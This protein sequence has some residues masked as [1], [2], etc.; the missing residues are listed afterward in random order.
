MQFITS[1][2]PSW[3]ARAKLLILGSMPGEESLRQKQ[4]Y[5]FKHNAFWRIMGTVFDFDPRLPY[6][7]RLEML[8]ENHVAL[9]DVLE[10]CERP[11]S[12]DG[13]IRNPK[14]NN[15][16]DLAAALP[17]LRKIICN[18]TAAGRYFEKFF[19][20]LEV[21]AEVLPSTSPAAARLTF[22]EKLARWR[23]A[24]ATPMV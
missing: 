24:L 9:W 20:G 15:I 4:Y 8:R 13:S 10:R 17:G 18:G 2:P 22:E 7:V 11:G 23:A 1:F 14:P 21:P 19:P 5:A 12:L 16:A 6:S 3:D